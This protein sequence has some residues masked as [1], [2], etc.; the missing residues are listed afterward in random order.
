MSASWTAAPAC[1]HPRGTPA[2][3]L[4][5][6]LAG[7]AG[8][9]TSLGFVAETERQVVEHLESHLRE[10][11]ASDLR[12]RKVVEQ[13]SDDEARHGAAARNAGARELPEAIRGLMRHT[14]RIMT[15][16]AYRI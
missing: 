16:T 4:I 11:P 7:L 15:R 13:M 1:W 10:L 2:H 5:G 6:A 9:R 8:D 12:S 3:W 14:A